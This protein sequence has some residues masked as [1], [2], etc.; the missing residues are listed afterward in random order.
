M[1]KARRVIERRSEVITRMG[2]ASLAA[3][4]RPYCPFRRRISYLFRLEIRGVALRISR[5][6][7]PR[8]IQGIGFVD[9]H[10]DAH[11]AACGGA[12]VPIADAAAKASLGIEAMN[13]LSTAI[14]LLD[15]RCHVVYA[16]TTAEHL[17]KR[18]TIFKASF[19]QPL[20]LCDPES[21]EALRKATVE[22]RR[23]TSVALQLCDDVGRPAIS[24]VVL[25]LRAPKWTSCGAPPILLA[26]NEWMRPRAIP[27]HWLSQLF[28]LTPAESS[29]TNWLVSGRTIDEYA[30]HR[31]V[32]VETVRSQL[33]AVLSKSGLSRQTQLVATLAR[34]PIEHAAP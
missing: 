33:K 12:W 23:H 9:G 13:A 17:L 4:M 15:S 30:L 19:S 16:N 20:S 27:D 22:A 11:D 8:T 6:G 7:C 28:G 25:P 21:N 5:Q 14:T 26:M 2:Y 18:R 29:V 1:P 31:G 3:D 34:L 10:R 24:A 32:S